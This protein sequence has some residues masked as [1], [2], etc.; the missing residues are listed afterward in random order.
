MMGLVPPASSFVPPAPGAWELERT[1]TTGPT[2]GFVAEAFPRAMMRGFAEGMKFYGALLDHF[3]VA[4]LHRF[5]YMCPRPV[6]AP[7]GANGPPRRF[8][9]KLLCALHPEIR[10]RNARAK[11]TFRDRL[12]RRDVALWDDE[13]KPANVRDGRA[14]LAEPIQAFSNAELSDHLRRAAEFAERTMYWHHR[15]SAC[16]VV[17]IGDFLAHVIDWTGM[18][19]EEILGVFGGL[20]PDSAG[21]AEEL[22]TLRGALLLDPEAYRLLL[23]NEP[24]QTI[25]DGL[26]ARPE[27]VGPAV[28][29][30]LS[31]VGWRIIGAYEVSEAHAL[32]HPELL[33]KIIRAAVTADEKTRRVQA[34]DR[35]KTLR[36][37]VPLE[38]HG[39]FDALFREA[40]LTYRIRDERNF[41]ADAIG[42]GLMRRA[43]LEA[44]TRLARD[45]RI[46][47]PDHLMDA[48][49]AEMAALL[50]GSGT[51]DAETLA[52]RAH[53]RRHASIDD[54]PQQLGLAPSGPPP[55][56]WLPPAA[57]RLQRAIDV[58][59]RLMF[60]VRKI[61]PGAAKKATM[62]NGNA[63][64]GGVHEG[65]ARVIAGPSELSKI[66]L[67]DILVTTATAPTF[68]VVL[69]LVSAIVT[70][71]GGALSHAAV[72]AREYGLPAVVGCVDATRIIKT[73]DTLRVNGDTGEIWIL[74]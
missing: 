43:I 26:A 30:Y 6:G 23:S 40:Q 58:V 41:Y 57:A 65:V 74:T 69:P 39:E 61:D 14:L 29:A 54:A 4:V 33:V 50:A 42:T 32:E 72:V 11:V 47:S 70:E 63:A 28:A 27:P 37:R 71:R 17:P 68:N 21:A 25:L 31:V 36:A 15:F 1:H 35:V 18:A 48:S 55:S 53:Y 38:R 66:Q 67:G 51:P 12:W 9:F 13:V 49:V 59:I 73:G 24:P 34:A 62:L 3:E 7:K 5:T 10:R 16:A 20:S 8:V 46:T 52:A 44:G 60:D 22:A 2:S 45:Q 56:D 19:P 64:G